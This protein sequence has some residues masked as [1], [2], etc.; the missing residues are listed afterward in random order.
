MKTKINH[1]L[2]AVLSLLVTFGLTHSAAAQT[3]IAFNAPVTVA[4]T[5]PKGKPSYTTYQQ[6]FSMKEDGSDVAQLTSASASSH[7]PKWSP[8]Q[9]YISFY[10]YGIEVMEAVGEANNGRTFRVVADA[11]STGSDWN[12]AGTMICFP[13]GTTRGLWVVNVD[14][15]T[16][17]VGTPILVREGMCMYPVWSPD[18][19]KIAFTFLPSGA[20]WGNHFIKVLDLETG[21][22]T[23][24][25]ML[26]SS[27]PNWSPDGT[28]MAF[29][30]MV[31]ATTTKGNKTTTNNYFE[32]F[33]ANVD[34]TA[35]TQLTNFKSI[36][37]LP[38]WSPDGE[39]LA[40]MSEING[41]RSIYKMDLSTGG[42][43][44]LHEGE[45]PNWNP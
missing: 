15:A 9:R 10:R 28:R 40:L 12:P 8:D 37:G 16:G 6:I 22:E 25:E 1:L 34:G 29:D 33:I 32:V 2:G 4:N 11:A 31:T 14:T 41:P 30:G 18:G 39:T 38:T 44:F 26:S 42:T 23:S 3:R 27:H 20:V 21:A 43:L 36:T 5:S 19:K 45:G 35:A 13:G 17:E 7:S 24:F